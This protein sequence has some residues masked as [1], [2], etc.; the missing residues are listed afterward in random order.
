MLEFNKSKEIIVVG[1]S[2]HSLEIVDI[3]ISKGYKIKGYSELVEKEENIHGIK[4]LGDENK[5]NFEYLKSKYLYFIAIGDNHLR[6]SK[7]DLLSSKSLKQINVIHPDT[8]ISKSLKIGYG[9][10]LSRNVSI[11]NS[12]EIGNNVIVNTAAIIE[13]NCKIETG[14]HIAPG[15]VI[16]GGVTIKTGTFIGANCIIRENVCIGKNVVVG[17]GSVVLNNIPDNSLVFGNP[18]KIKNHKR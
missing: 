1:L 4:F 14:S 17:A 13:H 5:S 15:A 11:N 7:S 9:N 6:K 8:S 18:S 3:I 16:C 10:F 2:G 12:V